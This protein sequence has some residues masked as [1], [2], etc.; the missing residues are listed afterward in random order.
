LYKKKSGFG[1]FRLFLCEVD[2]K[3]KYQMR[4][5]MKLRLKKCHIYAVC[6]VSQMPI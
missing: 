1:I 5:K 2:M 4:R 3:D 6:G